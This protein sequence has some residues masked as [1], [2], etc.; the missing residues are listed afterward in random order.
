MTVDELENLQRQNDNR[1]FGLENDTEI[2]QN[3]YKIITIKLNYN[4]SR[5]VLD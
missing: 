5:H 1:S 2:Q 3:S 4:E